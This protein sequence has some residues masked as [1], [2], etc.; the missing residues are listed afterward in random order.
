[1]RDVCP[2]AASQLIRSS[3]SAIAHTYAASGRPLMHCTP[4]CA[5]RAEVARPGA[6]SFRRAATRA[7]LR[8]Q[9]TVYC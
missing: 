2:S 9:S 5:A 6:A 8:P 1:M 7:T 3:S 4:H